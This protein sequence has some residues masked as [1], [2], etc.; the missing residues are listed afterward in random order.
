[1]SAFLTIA[2][3]L[4]VRGIPLTPVRRG[5]KRAFLPDFPTTA[6]ADLA[7]I[8]L[9]DGAYPDSNAA[10]VARAEEGGFFFW[11]VDAAD[12]LERIKAETGHDVLA[13]IKTFRV[14]SR[15]GRGHFYFS[16][17]PFTIANLPN[18]SQSY[19]K[20]QDW[21]LRVN[22][23]YVV[24]P[25]SIHPDTKQPYQA[26]NDYPITE[27]PQWLIEWWLSQRVGKSATTASTT[28]DTT[29]TSFAGATEKAEHV[30]A[31]E[32]LAS[33]PRNADG[34][35]ERGDGR[36]HNYMLT[37]G[38]FWAAM[39]LGEDDIYDILVELMEKNCAGPVDWNLVKAMAKSVSQYQAQM[40][41]FNEKPDPVKQAE[42]QRQQEQRQQERD[43]EALEDW[44]QYTDIKNAELFVNTHH[45]IVRAQ[46]GGAKGRTTWFF[47][48][49]A[50]W[51]EDSNG[52]V[53]G[54][55]KDTATEQMET[56][57]QELADAYRR[58]DPDVKWYE[59][60]CM[61][62]RQCCS[63]FRLGSMLNLAASGTKVSVSMT[64][65]DGLPNLVNF[66]NG[67]YDAEKL[68]LR[69][70]R[71]ED[72]LTQ[73][74]P[75]NYNPTAKCPKWSAFVERVFRDKPYM[76]GYLQRVVGYMLMG[77]NPEQVFFLFYG[78]TGGG[79][80]TMAQVLMAL[81][82]DYARTCPS[83]LFLLGARQSANAPSP[84]QADLYG[85]RLVVSEELEEGEALDSRM[86]KMVTGGGKVKARP[87]YKPPFEY[88]PDY[89]L[90]F[91]TNFTPK[92]SDFSGA[93]DD[94][95]RVVRME[96]RLRD[97]EEEIQ[98]FHEVLI[99]E[100]MEGI[101]AWAVEG[102]KQVKKKGLQDPKEVLL[103]TQKFMQAEN[104]VGE[105]MTERVEEADVLLP[106]SVA[107]ANFHA[108][109]T[110]RGE[111]TREMTQKWFGLRMGHLGRKS[112]SVNGVRG[113]QGLRLARQ[114]TYQSV[115]NAQ[116]NQDVDGGDPVNLDAGME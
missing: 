100:E 19:V 103:M 29:A 77:R 92:I 8:Q 54:L 116:T 112:E 3:P 69:P 106:S 53:V 18:L 6:T 2:E 94:R 20:D 62:A 95:L 47:W 83:G 42:Y 22:R 86:V 76:V 1:M 9:W 33:I 79:K 11:E 25:G 35:I 96:Q 16:H 55:A 70:H 74:I 56:S 102:L 104:V 67:T 87:L 110:A 30:G 101:L 115:G 73:V 4:T 39:G 75:Y 108:W 43:E 31:N 58:N 40:L 24:A 90:L 12:V 71:K 60:R 49:G 38:G 26:L 46:Y 82:G 61:A 80:T 88:K 78:I 81:L 64:Q 14:R 13:E 99:K 37:I 111:D 91:L 34:L 72:L 15:P 41:V 105:W 114:G 17:T 84:A 65:L 66:L 85:A 7:T 68:E 107:Y 32:K 28:T 10:C 23:E 52:T 50:R 109:A 63:D 5:T 44:M 89:K 27:A 57:I 45:E 48:D 21:S 51:K 93:I 113:Y 59:K 98:H 97:T 36:Y